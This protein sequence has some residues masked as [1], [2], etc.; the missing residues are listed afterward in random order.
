[1]LEEILTDLDTAAAETLVV[2]DTEYDMQM[3][4]SAGAYAV[5]I[6]HGVHSSERLLESGAGRCF[7][8]LIELSDWLLNRTDG[9]QTEV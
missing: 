9:L 3:A 5:G 7:A 6:G 1:M 2:G 4:R 8:D